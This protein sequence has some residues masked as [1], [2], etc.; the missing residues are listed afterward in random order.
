[1]KFGHIVH[2]LVLEPTEFGSRYAFI[3]SFQLDPGNT[4]K[5]GKRSESKATIYYEEKLAAFMEGNL[6]KEIITKEDFFRA[7]SCAGKIME[8]ESLADFLGKPYPGV[9]IEEAITF[10]L[11]G[12]VMRCKLDWISVELGL[13]I[14]IKSTVDESPVFFERHA[15]KLDY[16]RQAAIYK[17]AARQKFGKEF[18][19]L[20]GVVK[21]TAPHETAC[22]EYDERSS[23]DGMEEALQLIEI[24]KMRS[25]SNNWLAD[26]SQGN[27]PTILTTSRYRKKVTVEADLYDILYDIEEEEESEGSE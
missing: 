2:C 26:H 10:Q 3:P 15:E 7:R 1:M 12:L 23:A 21:P 16:F 24:F 25:A 17:E 6:Y 5:A 19:F 13:I 11:G 8:H 27:C 18:R 9:R 14:D 20:F 22:Y 4:T